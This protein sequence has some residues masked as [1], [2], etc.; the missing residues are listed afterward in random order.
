MDNEDIYGVGKVIHDTLKR[1]KKSL[2]LTTPVQCSGVFLIAAA[3]ASRT[4]QGRD[5]QT[6]G[7]N[8]DYARTMPAPCPPTSAVVARRTTTAS[9]RWRRGGGGEQTMSQRGWWMPAEGQVCR[10]R[11]SVDDITPLTHTHIQPSSFFPL[12]CRRRRR[13]AWE[14]GLDQREI[15]PV[16]LP[17]LLVKISRE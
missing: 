1:K 4:N 16:P 2:L 13:H 3:R 14:A 6:M 15:S 10:S 7:G 9:S 8:G 12:S 17:S 11:R 5:H